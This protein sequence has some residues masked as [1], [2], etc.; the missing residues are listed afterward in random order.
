[1]I[2]VGICYNAG[3]QAFAD[4][5]K[6]FLSGFE[7]VEIEAWDEDIHKE[8]RKSFMIKGH[9]A[10]RQ[11]PFCGVWKN[12]KALKGFYTEAGECSVPNITEFLIKHLTKPVSTQDENPHD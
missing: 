12:D 1:M 11:T 6:K 5:L 8:R 9:F 10:A 7:D 3:C 4:E 2:R